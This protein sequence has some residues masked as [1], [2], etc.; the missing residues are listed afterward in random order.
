[1]AWTALLDACVLYPTAT[2]DL[3]L[4]GAERDLYQVRWST[5]IIEELR[6]SLILDGRCS[7]E[8]ARGLLGHM[9]QAFP[10]AMVS[11]HDPLVPAMN[12]DPGDR[13][14]LAAAVAASA[15]VI[16]TDNVRHFPPVA[17]DRFGIEV[18]TPD[19]FLSYA[20]DLAPGAMADV[21]LQQVKD[22]ERPS[23]DLPRALSVLDERLPLL[24]S[25]LR[26]HRDIRTALKRA[27]R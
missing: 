24:A 19:E 21:F 8:Q 14:I 23:F 20:F 7:A 11:G 15:D 3:L 13:H 22:F 27:D 1:M 16:V 5:E 25:R 26:D 4:R 17:C 2:R 12:T 10:E 18:Q 9:L 6:R